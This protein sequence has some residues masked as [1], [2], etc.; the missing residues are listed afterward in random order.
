MMRREMR[1]L[2]EIEE[3]RKKIKGDWKYELERLRIEQGGFVE[4]C[5]NGPLKAQDHSL[6]SQLDNPRN[7]R[8]GRDGGWRSRGRN[9]RLGNHKHRRWD[10]VESPKAARP[11]RRK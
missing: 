10:G 2:N 9:Y 11:Q 7:G 5:L 3:A 6:L 8:M 4:F 1:R